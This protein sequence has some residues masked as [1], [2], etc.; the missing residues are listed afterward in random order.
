MKKLLAF[1]TYCDMSLLLNCIKISPHPHTISKELMGVP[2]ETQPSIQKF[3]SQ[4]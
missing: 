1:Y 3:F 2:V 4:N